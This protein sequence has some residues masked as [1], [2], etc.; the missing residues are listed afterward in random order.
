MNEYDRNIVSLLS[1]LFTNK[2]VKLFIGSCPKPFYLRPV[3]IQGLAMDVNLSLPFLTTNKVDQLHSRGALLVRGRARDVCLRDHRGRPTE[4]GRSPISHS[5]I[6]TS[7]AVKV[8][9]YSWGEFPVTV[10]A[11][12]EGKMLQTEGLLVGDDHFMHRTG[13]HLVRQRITGCTA[14]GLTAGAVLNMTDQE[15]TIPK[16]TRYGIYALRSEEEETTNT[17]NE[18]ERPQT[19]KEK[20]KW[21]IKEF[22]LQKSSFLRNPKHMEAALATLKKHWGVFSLNG[23]FGKTSLIKHHIETGTHNPINM[24]YRP[25]NPALESNLKEQLEEWLKHD[26]IKQ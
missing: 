5:F 3:V 4:S 19:N 9:S 25:I 8:S 15:V 17:N 7:A 6:Y 20:D 21:L 26:I 2:D 23:A 1:K 18:R 13:L 10:A 22:R 24:R 16:G 11:V 14:E 12:A